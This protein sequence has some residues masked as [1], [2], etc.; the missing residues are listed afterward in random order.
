MN[1]RPDADNREIFSKEQIP[2]KI[3]ASR[4]VRLRHKLQ[5]P[6][7]DAAFER[8]K[9]RLFLPEIP[10]YAGYRFSS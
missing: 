6:S 1:N 4:L 2:A 7:N 9:D 5:K 8:L 3:L 10:A